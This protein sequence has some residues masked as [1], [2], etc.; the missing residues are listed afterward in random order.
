MLRGPQR[1]M[2]FIVY[3]FVSET[4]F[5]SFSCLEQ[6]TM[7]LV[8]FS[9]HFFFPYFYF[10]LSQQTTIFIIYCFDIADDGFYRLLFYLS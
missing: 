1:T 9:K 4:R 5:H 7:L 3:C 2:F 10:V 8:L 6:T